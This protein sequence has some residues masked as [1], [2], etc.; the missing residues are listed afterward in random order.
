MSKTRYWLMKSEPTSYGFDDLLRDKRTRWDGVRNFQARNLLR[1]EVQKGD[2]VLF[3]HSN[4]EPPG[5]AGVAEVLRTA[6]PDPTQ[7]DPADD[8]HDPAS[9][10]LDPRWVAVDLKP[11]QR[12]TRFVPLPELKENPRLAGMGVLR[13]GNRLS[14]QRVTP[15]E[16]REV[17]RMGEA[18]ASRG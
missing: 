16:F 1:D 9:D 8:H 2:L 18:G 12:L 7:F 6:Y 3:Y 14:V 5:V 4:A 11:C 13:R 10:P 17:L 15:E